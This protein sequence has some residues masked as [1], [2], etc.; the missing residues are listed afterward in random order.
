MAALQVPVS[1]SV[2]QIGPT[3]SHFGDAL[4]HGWISQQ[5]STQHG[6]EFLLKAAK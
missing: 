5:L 1:Y 6:N 2:C 4:L 3:F